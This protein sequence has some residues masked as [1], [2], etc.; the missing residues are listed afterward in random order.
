[1]EGSTE[2]QFDLRITFVL[3][4]Y[5]LQ[6]RSP[7]S[8]KSLCHFVHVPISQSLPLVIGFV[9]VELIYPV[10]WNNNINIVHSA[11]R[12]SHTSQHPN[13][14]VNLLPSISLW[15][16]DGRHILWIQVAGAKGCEL[17]DPVKLNRRDEPS[18]G[19]FF[20]FL[21][22]WRWLV[23][24]KHIWLVSADHEPLCA[25]RFA[26]EGRRSTVNEVTSKL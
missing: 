1:M 10:E 23:A 4:I 2:K 25:D 21:D 18:M 14:L 19:F 7:F 16:L 3:T 22:E 15:T 12:R 6:R 20:S 26:R 13:Q 8:F 24:E 17:S 9:N 11:F 5:A